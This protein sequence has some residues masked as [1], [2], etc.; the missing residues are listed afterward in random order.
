IETWVQW[1]PTDAVYLAL[2][3]AGH[4]NQA[5]YFSGWHAFAF[6]DVRCAGF[7]LQPVALRLLSAREQAPG[8]LWNA[9]F[10][11][12]QVSVCRQVPACYD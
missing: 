4:C 7:G 1:G 11:E 9:T 8:G 10:D 5:T 3:A 6:G 2:T 12:M